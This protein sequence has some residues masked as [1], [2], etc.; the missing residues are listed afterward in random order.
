MTDVA[1][2]H[3]SPGVCIPWEE[4][5]KE[6]EHLLQGNRTKLFLKFLSQNC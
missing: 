3:K 1:D 6:Y 2:T 4:R 5:V